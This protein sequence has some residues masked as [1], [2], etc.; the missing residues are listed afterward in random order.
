MD[1]AVVAQCVPMARKA[2]AVVGAPHLPAL[3]S[4]RRLPATRYELVLPQRV[5]V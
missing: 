1:G 5:G 4:F 3:W 2:V